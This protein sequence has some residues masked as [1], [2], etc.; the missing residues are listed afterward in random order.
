MIQEQRVGLHGSRLVIHAR[1]RQ[2]MDFIAEI[3]GQRRAARQHRVGKGLKGR[4]GQLERGVCLRDED[5]FGYGQ[6]GGDE[7]TEA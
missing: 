4:V 7:G 1:D 3:C 5:A 2:R 6:R